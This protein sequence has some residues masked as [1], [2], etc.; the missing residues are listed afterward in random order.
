MRWPLPRR[1]VSDMTM[2]TDSRLVESPGALTKAGYF[3]HQIRESHLKG[4]FGARNRLCKLASEAGF[5]QREIGAW[6]GLTS[7]GIKKAIHKDR[8]GQ[9]SP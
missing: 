4:R 2:S 5:K 6:I 7:S 9:T 3:R 1:T 8:T